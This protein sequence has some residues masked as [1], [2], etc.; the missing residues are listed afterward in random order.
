MPESTQAEN[1]LAQDFHDA[2]GTAP[3]GGLPPVRWADG[4]LPRLVDEGEA[5]L[6][7][8]T[9]GDPV[10]A[11]GASL[12][13]V[14]RK[15]PMTVRGFQNNAGAL[16]IVQVEKTWLVERL[17]LAAHWEK[18]DNRSESWRKINCPDIVANTYLSRRGHWKVPRLLSVLSAPTLRPDGSLLQRPGYDAEMCALFDACGL[19]FPAVP[20]QPTRDDAM[21]AADLLYSAVDSIPF[22]GTCDA[23]VAVALMLTAM[24]RRS[25]P[26][27]PLGVI[28]APTPGSGKSLLADCM[29]I[30]GSGASSEPLQFPNSDEEAEKVMLSA[31]IDGGAVILFDNIERPIEG[32][33]LCSILTSETYQ[34]RAL[35]RN[36]MITVPTA[37]L[38]LA[39]GN[40]VVIQGD[41]RTRTLLCRIDP[42]QENPETRKFDTDLRAEFFRRRPELIAAGLT[43]MRAYL[44]ACD[45][46]PKVKPWGRFEHWSRFCREPLLWL[47]LSDPC[48]SYSS[49]AAT[50]P[51]RLEH[52]QMVNLWRGT[53]GFDAHTAREAITAAVGGA[54]DLRDFLENIARDRAGGVSSKRLG[55]WLRAHADR[56]IGDFMFVKAGEDANG[57]SLWKVKEIKTVQATG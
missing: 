56:I 35:G 26:S 6:I 52:L 45:N 24:V 53:F 49:I 22:V 57:T 33:W 5:A 38:F 1:E 8:H 36:E 46:L 12:V 19:E 31:L 28:T 32:A 7:A 15:P 9:G 37:T 34:G 51:A 17:T 47:G 23:S 27:A 55:N 25:L 48:E 20:E 40:A 11:R 41:L 21:A 44:C 30:L 13:R 42:K 50:D 2:T 10:F 14:V 39:T 16:G 3:T 43:L 18:Y 29:A 4:A 54:G